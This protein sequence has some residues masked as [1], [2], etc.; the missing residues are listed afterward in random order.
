[1]FPKEYDVSGKVVLITGAVRGIGKGIAEVLAEAGAEIALNALTN[2]FVVDTAREIATASESKVV[3]ILADVTKT[4]EVN[5][6]IE[7]VLDEFGRLDV[8]VNCLGDAIGQPL[9]KFTNDATI[10]I[11]DEDLKRIID[12]NLTAAILCTRAAG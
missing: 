11:S 12:I 5:Q 2:R 8:L 9:I 6:L 7:K 10:P 4:Q 1:M 3:P